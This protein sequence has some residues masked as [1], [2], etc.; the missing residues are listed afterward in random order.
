[1]SENV[2]PLEDRELLAEIARALIERPT[3][4]HVE[5]RKEGDVWALYLYVPAQDRGRVIGRKGRTISAIRNLFSSI[6]RAD[7]KRLLVKIAD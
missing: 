7:G 4:V 6:G 1:M 3:E 5:E 2:L